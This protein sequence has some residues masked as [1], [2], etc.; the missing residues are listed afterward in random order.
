MPRC[1]ACRRWSVTGQLRTGEEAYEMVPAASPLEALLVVHRDGL[2]STRVRLE[3]DCFVF[4]APGDRGSSICEPG[5]DGP[6]LTAKH[7][8]MSRAINS[9]PPEIQ[10]APLTPARWA[11]LEIVFGDGRGACGQCWCMYWRMPRRDFEASIGA[12]TRQLFRARVEARPP[13]G[14]LAYRD[15]TPVGWVQVGRAPMCRAGMA[16]VASRRLPPRL[17]PTTRGCGASLAL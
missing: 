8:R 2:G 16:R 9:H 6:E 15:G 1:T 17:Q 3:G 12:K 11:D 4:A 5:L 13:P 7:W 14:L 10:I